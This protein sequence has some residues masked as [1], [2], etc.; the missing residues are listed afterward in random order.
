M[1]TST[2]APAHTDGFRHEAM[3]YEGTS[4]FL[5][6]AT[7]FVRDAVAAEEPTLVVVP[8]ER[9]APLRAEFAGDDTV[10][11]ADMGE[12]GANPARIIPAWREFA[13]DHAGRRLRGIG[14]PIWPSRSAAELLE[15]Q[16][17]ESLL[18]LAFADASTF[19]LLCP[20]DTRALSAEVI[21]E[22]R[23]NHPFVL[24]GE[25]QT[26]STAYRGLDAVRAPFDDPLPEPPEVHAEFSFGP[27]HL[28]AVRAFVSRQAVDAGLDAERVEDL[29]LA[30]NELA[31]N[32][33]LYGGA[34][35][36]VR[37][38]QDRDGLVC[39]VRDDGTIDDPLIGRLPPDTSQRGGRGIWMANQICDLVQLRS[40]SAGT[41]VRVH[42][43]NR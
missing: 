35:G 31:T 34:H 19:W 25:V 42:V 43:R 3:L 7:A 4:E 37:V 29:V 2:A 28:A 41:V 33:L 10:F 36:R 15:C 32:S 40:S 26:E 23:R 12:V 38:W 14:E 9:M 6:S 39:E 8:R 16:R 13:S 21:E 11:F 30:I 5:T 18:N 17:H 20:Y 27:G 22:A 1:L 24:V